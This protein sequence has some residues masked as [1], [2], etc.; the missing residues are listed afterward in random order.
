MRKIVFIFT[1][2]ILYSFTENKTKTETGFS[3]TCSELASN[4]IKYEHG[5]MV[6]NST[7]KKY[8]EPKNFAKILLNV[9]KYD[10]TK[11]GKVEKTNSDKTQ[12][13]IWKNNTP[14]GAV[15]IEKKTFIATG[16]ECKGITITDYSLRRSVK[17]KYIYLRIIEGEF[18]GLTIDKTKYLPF[19]ES[20]LVGADEAVQEFN[21]TEK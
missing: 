8:M 1:I 5:K 17:P 13:T 20:R 14:N 19:F 18:E 7:T 11:I 2:V 6:Y 21:E 4:F 9:A 3:E 10:L 12:K 16:K 15:I